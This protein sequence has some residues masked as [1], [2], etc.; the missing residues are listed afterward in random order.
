MR[1]RMKPMLDFTPDFGA[2]SLLK[3]RKVTQARLSAIKGSLKQNKELSR[4]SIALLKRMA[5]R[6]RQANMK[7]IEM[8]AAEKP[9]Q[10]VKYWFRIE[11]KGMKGQALKLEL[12]AVGKPG[13]IKEFSGKVREFVA[14]YYNEGV[15]EA[16]DIGMGVVGIEEREAF[17]ER[18]GFRMNGKGDYMSYLHTIEG[19]NLKAKWE[20]KIEGIL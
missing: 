16:G 10:A 3:R 13:K 4:R 17:N 12:F 5:G 14:E 15:S 9:L 7:E 6:V 1:K 2:F 20:K 19:E 8:K 18:I 11:T